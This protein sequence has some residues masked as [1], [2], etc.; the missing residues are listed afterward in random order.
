[1]N[2]AA[3]FLRWFWG[4]LPPLCAQE[5]LCRQ[6][7]A[8]QQPILFSLFSVWPCALFTIIISTS[9]LKTE[10]CLFPQRLFYGTH[11]RS[12]W[13]LYKILMGFCSFLLLSSP[14]SRREIL[15]CILNCEFVQRFGRKQQIFHTHANPLQ[16]VYKRSSG[17]G[18]RAGLLGIA[19]TSQDEAEDPSNIKEQDIKR[20]IQNHPETWG[21]DLSF[22]N[23]SNIEM[24][25]TLLSLLVLDAF[26]LLQQELQYHHAP[27]IQLPF[28]II[29]SLAVRIRPQPAHPYPMQ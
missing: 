29:S 24:R 7:A 4:S 20:R 3:S 22:P 15:A 12:V 17:Q 8:I 11:C 5:M 23:K 10:I 26:L 19:L 14:F 9:A 6:Q 1:M 2:F 18:A 21:L 16:C 28:P 13:M 25:R 27:N